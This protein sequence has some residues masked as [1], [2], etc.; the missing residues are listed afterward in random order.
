MINYDDVTKA[1]TNKHNPNW[2]QI[3]D[4]LYRIIG[5]S[6]SG[7]ANRWLNLIKQQSGDDYNIINNIYESKRSKKTYQKHE[8]LVLKWMKNQR[9]L[10]DI[11][12]ICRMF[13]QVL[14]QKNALQNDIHF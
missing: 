1:K 4:N 2:P 14:I 6:G 3:F 12:I 5:G 7:K 13:I 11:Q 10:L 8:T 9:F